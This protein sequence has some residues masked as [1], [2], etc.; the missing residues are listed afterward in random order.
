V[1]TL[2][3]LKSH[4]QY[5]EHMGCVKRCLEHL[6]R[7][8]SLPWLFGGTTN[9][10]VLNM[11]D[12]V[13]VDAALAWA[14]E[15]LFDL[16]RNLGFRREGVVHNPGRGEITSPDLFRQKQREAWKFVRSKIDQGIPCYG[17]ELWHIPRYYVI[18]GYHAVKDGDGDID[19]FHS[20]WN[21]G[22]LC[23]WDKIG[24]FDVRA[25]AVYS[26]ELCDP[27]P[28]VQVVREALISVLDRVERPDGWT[29][30]PRYT[31]GLLGYAVWGDALEQGRA[32]LDG[33]AY[34]NRVWLEAR[35]MAV[36]FLREAQDRLSL[37][38]RAPLREAE[39]H[40]AV[41]RDK[42]RALAE[43]HPERPGNADWTS[44]LTSPR[45]AALVR[46][47]AAAERKGVSSLRDVVEAL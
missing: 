27:A 42:L 33:A 30:M 24:T 17:W 40:Y 14:S 31:S 37:R 12:T 29:S 10:F 32:N 38:S 19:A 46:E 6:G 36:A 15:T 45:G 3:G 28:D 41:V 34:I 47:A 5:N 23:P 2:E 35:D 7:D 39:A 16:A 8:M 1:K 13:F 18:N 20:A 11:N 21:S 25:V 22:T 26:I 9:A 44:T 4:R 43:M